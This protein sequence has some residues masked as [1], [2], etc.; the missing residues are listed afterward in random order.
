MNMESF[1]MIDGQLSL[2]IEVMGTLHDF[3]RTVQI[4]Y[5]LCAR[6]DEVRINVFQMISSTQKTFLKILTKCNRNAK[7]WI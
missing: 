7:Y 6:R 2:G 5:P 4:F 3:W 1:I